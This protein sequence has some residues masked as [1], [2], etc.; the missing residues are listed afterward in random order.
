LPESFPTGAKAAI[1]AYTRQLIQAF[2]ATGLML[3]ADR[4]IPADNAH[5]HIRRVIEAA[6]KYGG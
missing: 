4:T 6:G 2:G 3:G 5:D 1:K